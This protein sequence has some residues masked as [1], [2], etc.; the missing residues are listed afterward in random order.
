M[1][2]AEALKGIDVLQ[3]KMR[4]V[5]GMLE[6]VGDML[7]GF[8]RMKDIRQ[9]S[10]NGTLITVQFVS[11]PFTL[12]LWSDA[13]NAASQ[14]ANDVDTAPALGLGTVAG[15]ESIKIEDDNDKAHGVQN[16][17]EGVRDGT[18]NVDNEQDIIEDLGARVIDGAHAILNR[19]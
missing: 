19:Y 9:K 7:K 6:G 17:A 8:E 4:G 11:S 15:D 14:T 5:E 13:E 2:A 3:D 12:S 10:I 16:T 1:A 18:R